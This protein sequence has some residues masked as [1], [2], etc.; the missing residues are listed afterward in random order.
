MDVIVC[1]MLLLLLLL[2]LYYCSGTL[3]FFSVRHLP[4]IGGPPMDGSSR[5]LTAWVEPCG[6][7]I[8]VRANVRLDQPTDFTRV[9]RLPI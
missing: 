2:L 7:C 5:R 1:A 9:C 4:C 8:C 6:I 3:F